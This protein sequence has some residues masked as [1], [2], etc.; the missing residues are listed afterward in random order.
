MC[1]TL[2][3]GIFMLME[4]KHR[5]LVEQL[6]QLRFLVLTIQVLVCHIADI[7]ATKLYAHSKAG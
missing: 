2:S 3:T 6:V 7:Y 4:Q 1:I 5:H